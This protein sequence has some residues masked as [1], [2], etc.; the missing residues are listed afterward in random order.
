M[1]YDDTTR[2]IYAAEH[3]GRAPPADYRD[4][5]WMRW[6]AEKVDEVAKWFVQEIRARRPG[7]VLSLS[8]A[9]YPW[10]WENYLLAWPTWSAWTA[11]DRLKAATFQSAA[12]RTIT[13]HWDE[14][15]PQAYRFSVDAFANTWRQQVE[16]VR[17]SGDDRQRDLMAGIRIVGDG[18]DSSWVQLRD[19]IML[20]REMQNG[21]HVLWFSR[22]VLDLYSVELSKFYA[23]S[24]RARTPHFD[25]NW[26]QVALPLQ[27]APA[28]D[29]TAALVRWIGTTIPR[30]RYRA[31][32]FAS[33]AWH[34]L[35]HPS[36]NPHTTLAGDIDLSVP[37]KFTRIELIVD[38]RE[39]M[40]RL[41]TRGA[42]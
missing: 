25:A 41:Q 10:S 40:S 12:S 8:P 32:G 26:R 11:A 20:A 4:P 38:R 42:Q 35:D 6:R 1:G 22:G 5:A 24:G 21:G 2:K 7:L 23:A 18:N 27:R 39:A 36:L 17:A 19:S 16:A 34:Y 29:A 31:I 9:V 30:D 37:A 15:I 28:I 33:G 3:G 13:P 14:F